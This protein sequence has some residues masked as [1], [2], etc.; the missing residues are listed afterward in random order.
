MTSS[1]AGIVIVW[2]RFY[3]S[4]LGK[5]D[6]ESRV[7]LQFCK[8]RRWSNPFQSVTSQSS[9]ARKTRGNRNLSKNIVDLVPGE[10]LTYESGLSTFSPI[11]LAVETTNTNAALAPVQHPIFALKYSECP[12]DHSYFIPT[13]YPRN[14]L[15][16]KPLTSMKK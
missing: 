11:K 4:L 12:Q 15:S 3:S 16:F 10:S 1:V 2:Q 5:N 13:L 7:I 14:G 6:E 9:V 8:D